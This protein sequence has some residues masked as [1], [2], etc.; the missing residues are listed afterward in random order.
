VD[1]SAPW[2]RRTDSIATRWRSGAR[3]PAFAIVPACVGTGFTTQARW[4]LTH[5]ARHGCRQRRS[6]VARRYAGL[7]L[8]ELGN[9]GYHRLSP[10]PQADRRHARHPNQ[11]RNGN[12]R[13]IHARGDHAS[14]PE[15][16]LSMSSSRFRTS[17]R[18]TSTN[19]CRTSRG[20]G[21]GWARFRALRSSKASDNRQRNPT[22]K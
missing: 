7:C 14:H 16:S 13:S 18:Y 19:C 5:E 4:G 2:L 1:L 10:G 11:L 22:G 21:S 17:S 15:R 8:R 12:E 3:A 20:N 9:L 6:W